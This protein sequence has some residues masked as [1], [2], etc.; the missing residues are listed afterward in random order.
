MVFRLNGQEVC[1]SVAKYNAGDVGHGHSDGGM[2]GMLSDMT[3]CS[4]RVDVKKGD[5]LSI[6]AFYDMEKHPA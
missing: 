5:K 6:E 4:K 3:G 2:S 1:N